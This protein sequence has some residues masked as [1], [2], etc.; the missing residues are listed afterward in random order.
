MTDK[1]IRL[2]RF[3]V[4]KGLVQ[5]RERARAVIMAGDVLVNKYPIDKP[6]T[7]NEERSEAESVNGPPHLWPRSQDSRLK[8]LKGKFQTRC[9]DEPSSKRQGDLR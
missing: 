4:E 7:M 5:S 1:K 8:T 9:V 3:L 2:D 6:G